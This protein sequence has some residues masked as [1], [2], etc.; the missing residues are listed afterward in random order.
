[1]TEDPV[2]PELQDASKSSQ[3]NPRSVGQRP[4]KREAYVTVNAL[5]NLMST[6]TDT[7]L[8]Q[9]TEQ[10]KKTMEAVISM[11]P[12][13]TFDD[14]PTAGCK[15]SYKHAPT[16][17]IVEVTKGERRMDGLKKEIMTSL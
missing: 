10:V 6:M 7:I 14:V 9:V 1:M 17:S 4:P 8:Q 11:R 13:P 5:K 2:P 16:R 3:S 15:S 12:L